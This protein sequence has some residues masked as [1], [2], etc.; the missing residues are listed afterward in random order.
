[1]DL[2]IG[3]GHTEIKPGAGRRAAPG[4]GAGVGYIAQYAVDFVLGDGRMRIPESWGRCA[5]PTNLF[6]VMT[7]AYRK[8]G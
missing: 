8:P 3:P 4:P 7:A 5:I 2:S 6:D 1:M